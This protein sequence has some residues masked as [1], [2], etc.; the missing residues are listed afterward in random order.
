MLGTSL[1]LGLVRPLRVQA[2]SWIE[3][4]VSQNVRDAVSPDSVSATRI[5]GADGD[6]Y[7]VQIDDA[8]KRVIE[9]V[10]LH[11]Q[12]TLPY[13]VA[14]GWYARNAAYMI[15]GKAYTFDRYGYCLNP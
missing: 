5:I 1:M 7:E 3:A 11:L 8:D 12:A 10:E 4:L 2:E 6:G 14:G 15:N 13:A 9:G